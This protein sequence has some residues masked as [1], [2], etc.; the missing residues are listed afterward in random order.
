MRIPISREESQYNGANT[1]A[2]KTILTQ[3][4]KHQF[5]ENNPNT[6]M[7]TPVPRK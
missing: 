1:S 7:Q 3:L 4:C 2:K 6:I 5:Q